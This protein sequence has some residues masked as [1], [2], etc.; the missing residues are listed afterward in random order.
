MVRL[1]M[2]TLSEGDV[3]SFDFAASPHRT[4]LPSKWRT[5]GVRNFP[6]AFLMRTCFPFSKT[7]TRE[8]VV[9]RSIPMLAKVTLDS[10]CFEGFPNAVWPFQGGAIEFLS[11]CHANDGCCATQAMP[12][13]IGSRAVQL[14]WAWV[15]KMAKSEFIRSQ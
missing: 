7:L 8:F 9:P 10:F 4:C 1:N 15:S 2:A 12:S 13:E 14:A 6:S 5:D 3:T 11:Q